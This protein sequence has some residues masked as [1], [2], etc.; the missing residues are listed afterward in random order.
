M[1][2]VFC[3]PAAA[4]DR[5]LSSFLTVSSACVA[6]AP[7][8]V[9]LLDV[10]TARELVG[11]A[12]KIE[13]LLLEAGDFLEQRLLFVAPLAQHRLSPL[14]HSREW[15]IGWIVVM[16]FPWGSVS[17]E[18]ATLFGLISSVVI[19]ETCLGFACRRTASSCFFSAPRSPRPGP[20]AVRWRYLQV[21]TCRVS[22]ES[23]ELQAGERVRER[24]TLGLKERRP[25]IWNGIRA[26]RVAGRVGHRE[27]QQGPP[28]ARQ[29]VAGG[30]ITRTRA[31]A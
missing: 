5:C 10:V 2:M 22:P 28:R 25:R 1:R 27:A 7:R 19:C 31:A 26:T 8:L 13:R 17:E 9:A 20:S 4:R 15:S 3:S 29:K 16:I 30:I 11:I 12:A 14:V 6:A 23:I 24:P 21:R 18:A